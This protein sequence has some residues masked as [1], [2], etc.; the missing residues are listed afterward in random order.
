MKTALITGVAG[1]DGAYLAH[2][3]Q[4][5][6][7][8]VIGTVAQPVSDRSFADAYLADVDLR[9][10]DLTDMDAM[11]ETH[12]YGAPRRDLQPGFDQLGR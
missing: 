1:Q 2:L 8:Q 11:Q 5:N 10:V 12:R 3:L 4:L 7:Y 9:V 6:G